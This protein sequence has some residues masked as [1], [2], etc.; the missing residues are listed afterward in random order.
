MLPLLGPGRQLNED[1][2]EVA[3]LCVE[4]GRRRRRSHDITEVVNANSGVASSTA[5]RHVVVK[6]SYRDM[7][8]SALNSSDCF[9][10]KGNGV[11]PEEMVIPCHRLGMAVLMQCW[12]TVRSRRTLRVVSVVFK[13]SSV[14]C[15]GAT[16]GLLRSNTDIRVT[17]CGPED[18]AI[19][20][21]SASVHALTGGLMESSS[22]RKPFPFHGR[23]LPVPLFSRVRGT[24]REGSTRERGTARGWTYGSSYILSQKSIFLSSILNV[25]AFYLLVTEIYYKI[26]ESKNAV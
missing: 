23:S 16:L 8:S 12:S 26:L 6:A 21:F 9:G 18:W 13:E 24:A 3:E 19:A 11:P 22:V 25:H 17:Q 1:Q 2:E 7:F 14:V 5:G 15:G 20:S 4:A 10:K